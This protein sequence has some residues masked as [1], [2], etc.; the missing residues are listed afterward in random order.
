MKSLYVFLISIAISSF[1][2]AEGNSNDEPKD[3]V[4]VPAQIEQNVRV[5][6]AVIDGKD[7]EVLHLPDGEKVEIPVDLNSPEILASG[8]N[9]AQIAEVREASREQLQLTLQAILSDDFNGSMFVNSNG[10][11]ASLEPA[12]LSLRKRT[13]NLVRKVYREDKTLRQSLPEGSA[14]T[15]RMAR[16]ARYTYQFIFAETARALDNY[17]V[18][19]W[20]AKSRLVEYGFAIDFKFEPQV[21][22]SKFAPFAKVRSMRKNYE[23]IYDISYNFSTHSLVVHRRLRREKGTG[24]LGLPAFKTEIKTYQSDGTNRPIRGKSWYPIAPPIASFVF[25]SSEHYFAQGVSF[26]VNSGELIPGSTLTNTFTDFAQGTRVVTLDTPQKQSSAFFKSAADAFRKM[27]G[28]FRK[29][30]SA[31]LEPESKP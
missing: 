28:K 25:D 7:F 9:A 14:A 13:L 15:A 4:V 16:F 5:E 21:F 1:G 19:W 29:T 10:E 12:K 6:S 20:Q 23:F 22:I 11:A 27:L 2:F 8:L 26:G 3:A 31:L 30:C 17:L 18:D 24:G